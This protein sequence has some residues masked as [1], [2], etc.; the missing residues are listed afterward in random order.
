MF[1]VIIYFSS[2]PQANLTFY[3][4]AKILLEVSYFFPWWS[5]FKPTAFKKPIVPTCME[6]KTLKMTG[7][8]Q[9]NGKP[10]V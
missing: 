8:N 9:H 3:R 5:S 4:N 10:N 6:R 1:D 7:I 2:P